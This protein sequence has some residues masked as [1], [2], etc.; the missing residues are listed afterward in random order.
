MKYGEFDDEEIAKILEMRGMTKSAKEVRA[1]SQEGKTIDVN[2]IIDK[3][4]ISEYESLSDKMKSKIKKIIASL[5][6]ESDDRDEKETLDEKEGKEELDPDKKKEVEKIKR[7]NGDREDDEKDKSSEELE[8]KDE[9]KKENKEEETPKKDEYLAKLKKLHKMKIVD[10]KDQ[11][12]TDE[13]DVD[14]YYISMMVL[15]KSLNR[16]RAAYIKEYGAE[17]LTK[18]ENQYLQEENKYKRTLINNMDV[19]LAKLRALDEKLD[20][21]L[22]E[23]SK[24]QQQLEDESISIDTYNDRINT[25]EKDKLDTLWQINRLNPELLEEKQENLNFREKLEKRMTTASV[26]KQKRK[27]MSAL[28][29]ARTA[30]IKYDEK[31]QEG[32]AEKAN[33]KREIEIKEAINEKTQRLEEIRNELKDLDMNKSEDRKRAGLL[34]E[35]YHTLTESKLA[36]EKQQEALEK[37]MKSDIQDYGDLKESEEKREESTTEFSENVKDIDFSEQ[38]PDFMKQYIDEV[39]PEP[40]NPAEARELL[41]NMNKITEEAREEQ[42]KGEPEE[43]KE[44]TLFRKK[45]GSTS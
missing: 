31:G 28:N 30:G 15:Q 33:D 44:K 21:I 8:E 10:Y 1:N 17:E 25:L 6:E 4:P 26:E 3:S 14:R 35:E 36:L 39:V 37:N 45:Y 42:E 18:L 2:D 38:T 12:K 19:A 11:M 24:L 13:V 5:K 32:V 23:M 43:D 9:D 40:S 16:Q 20:A 34:I 29:K 27:D 41:D 22:D 7:E